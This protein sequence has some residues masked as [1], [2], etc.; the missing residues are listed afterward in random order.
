MTAFYSDIQFYTARL[1]PL[2]ADTCYSLVIVMKLQPNIKQKVLICVSH[3][4]HVAPLIA[5]GAQL[6]QSFREGSG[7]VLHIRHDDDEEPSWSDVYTHRLI[8]SQCKHHE[9][10]FQKELSKGK[11]IDEVLAKVSLE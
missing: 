1:D 10:H 2:C 8:E 6:I 9:L 5:Y 4:A 3:P 7:I 11:S